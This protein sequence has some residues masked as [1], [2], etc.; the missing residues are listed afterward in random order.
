MPLL[1]ESMTEPLWRTHPLA[2]KASGA[3]FEWKK[4]KL[5]YRIGGEGE[6]LLLL[7]GFPTSSWDWKDVWE[8]LTHQ[9]KVL[10]LDYLGFGFSEKPKDGH[11]SI[12]EYADQVEF[13]LQEQGI[14][15]LHILAHDLGDT[16]AQ[17][18]VARFREKLSGQRI[19]GPDLESVF[20]LN[21]GIFPE[22]HR[23][24]A[25]Q[26]LLNG[27]LGFLFSR[28]VNKTSFQKSFSEVF[29]P[30]TKPVQ[31][32]LDG[33]W[34][35]VNNGGGKLIYHK[36]IRYMRERKIFRDRWVGA[37]LDSPIPYALA[38]GLE[39]PVSGRHVVDRLR[40][41]RPD[42]KVYELPGIGHYP[43]TEAADQVLKAYS[44]FRSKL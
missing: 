32:E 26:K 5:F 41:M 30:N 12:F 25:V 11:Y 3:F 28:L 37:I 17:E 4:R 39:D 24:R 14:K 40:E 7:H 19:G 35:C 6:A 27:P 33:F 1:E 10:T 21:G 38:D 36:L 44:N 34:E 9:Y 8:T 31:E 2:W 15:K 16:V 20:F 23:P 43:Q 42:A 29:G 18:L 13:F 22:T